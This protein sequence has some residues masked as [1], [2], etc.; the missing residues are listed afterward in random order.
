M[1]CFP[2]IESRL[3]RMGFSLIAG[4]DEAGRGPLA[5]PVVSAAV[6][7]KNKINTTEIKDS[8]KLT[9]KKR[10]ELFDFILKNC[11]DYAISIVSHTEIDKINILNCVRVA[12]ELCIKGL[13]HKPDIILIDGIDKQFIKQPFY[14]MKKGEDK[15]PSIAAASILAKVTRD[16]IMRHYAK[17]YSKYQFEKHMG[18]G[19]RLH[20]SLIK[21]YGLCD[22]HRR[23]YNIKN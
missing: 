23:S 6:I 2:P 10:I 18:Y 3:K 16:L 17:E 11:I 1:S 22:I 7:L 8:K 20:R 15:S 14:T 19:T 9:P 21:K 4:I 12:N 13:K 5:G